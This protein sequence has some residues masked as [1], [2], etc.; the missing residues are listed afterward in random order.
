MHAA[1]VSF[2]SFASPVLHMPAPVLTGMTTGVSGSFL[3][4]SRQ[5]SD[6]MGALKGEL[7]DLL[8][9][10]KAVLSEI[11]ECRSQTERV[12]RY[13]SVIREVLSSSS[14]CY[15]DDRLMFFDGRSY[16]EASVR[17]LSVVLSN[18][19]TPLGVGASDIRKMGDMPYAVIWE[20]SFG[21][22]SDKICFSNCVYGMSD[23]RAFRFSRRHIT[24]YRLPYPY[25]G[26]ASCPRW[27]SFLSEVLPDESERMCL[28]EFFG[29]CYIDREELSVEKFAV[30]VGGGSNGKSVV[31]DVMK[32]VIGWDRVSYLSPDQLMDSRQVVSVVGKRLNFAPDVRRGASFDS[33]LKA[34]ASGQDVQGW[35]L[36]SGNVVVKC[37]PL[38]FALNEMP[39]FRDTTHAFFRRMMLFSFDVTIPP[40]RQN[41]S[42]ASEIAGSEL[43][44]IFRWVMEGR[45]RLLDSRGAF[46]RC[47]RMD[48]GLRRLERDARGGGGP[49]LEYLDSIGLSAVPCYNG[50]PFVKV[51]A[52]S[53]FDGLGGAVSRD[54]ITRELSSHGV[55]RD[56]GTEVRYYLYKKQYQ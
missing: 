2:V 49:V 6:S 53:I 12:D 9:E 27:M 55:R 31:F 22:D 19:L 33:A 28:Q 39:R 41:R 18:L 48:D 23:G 5:T 54:M 56:R 44:G 35:R 21:M 29:M 37:P 51:G 8:L 1:D 25:D 3:S 30:F 40:H 32:E 17:Q 45:R 46:T 26:G 20:R 16:V 11:G 38:V 50:Q 14:L 34:L 36:Y 47:C 52:G 7:G 42:L 43:P 4:M 15:V 10:R 24:D 13:V